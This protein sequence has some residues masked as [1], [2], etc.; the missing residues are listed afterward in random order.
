MPT[1]NAKDILDAN[2]AEAVNTLQ[3][4]SAHG[5]ALNRAA[6]LLAEAL[7][8]GRTLLICGN[9]G[10]A[11]D[12]S[13]IAAEIVG[14]FVKERKGYAAIAL[15]DSPATLTAV[16]NDYGFDE[17]FARQVEAYGRPGDV[18]LAI[19][20]SGNSPNVLKAIE[21]AKALGLATITLLGKDGGQARGQ[22]DVEFVV[23]QDVTARIQEAHQ[24]IYHSLCEAVDSA[25]AD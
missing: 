15:S 18:L 25:L 12:A 4:L 7:K 8:A 23:R 16:S 14:R 6:S 21:Q 5:E 20:T 17:V 19:S 24:L 11:A 2:I 9:G 13:H 3:N 22:A 10:S 1:D